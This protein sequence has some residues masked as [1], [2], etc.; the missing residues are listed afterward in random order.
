[1][2]ESGEKAVNGQLYQICFLVAAGRK[3]LQSQEAIRYKPMRYENRIEFS[4]FP[5]KKLFGTKR[6][7][8]RDVSLWFE[9]CIALGLEDVKLLCPFDIKDRQFLGFSNTTESSVLCFFKDN[10]VT[11]FTPYWEF[12]SVQREWNILYSEHECPNPPS[13][14]PSFEDN[15]D[16]FRKILIKIKD[17]AF[18]IDCMNF[19]NVFSDALS[20]LDGSKEYPDTKYGLE[21]PPLPP[22]NLQ[23]FEAASL[24]DVFG[25]MGSWNDSPPYMAHE[26]GLDTEY[27]T[28]SA[29]L[30]K[31]IRLASLY[32]VNEW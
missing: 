11:Y 24:A 29:E 32:A 21:L 14:K 3:T 8:A 10:S 16:S 25:A 19:A 1:M 31:N 26:K 18:R 12:D 2:N 6:Y 30:L 4:F 28:L 5:R 23:I 7:T 27:E 15:T 17:F 13:V 20:L 22:A 9:H